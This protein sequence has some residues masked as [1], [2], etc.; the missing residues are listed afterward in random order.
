MANILAYGISMAQQVTDIPKIISYQGQLTSSSG[1]I[2][3]DGEY[4][5]TITLYSD[6]NGTKPIWFD[7]YRTSVR[8]GIF[9]IMLGNSKA[10]PTAI[11][12]QPLWVGAVV[13]GS[14]EMRPL[15]MLSAAAYA[16]NIP[17]ESVTKEKMGTNYIGD[18]KLDGKPII[19]KGGTLNLRSGPGMLLHFDRL[20]NS[21]TLSS[22]G[23]I[24]NSKPQT[25]VNSVYWSEN[26]NVGT[27]AGPN[28]IG[29][30]DTVSLEIH[31]YHSNPDSALDAGRVMRFEMDEG[32][33]PN[34]IGGAYTNYIEDR[35]GSVIMGGGVPGNPNY[36]ESICDNS[37]IAG[38]K[39]NHILTNSVNSAII[40]GVN[41]RI[42][43][44]AQRAVINGGT[45]NIIADTC[46]Y[47]FIGGGA[48]NL[49]TTNGKFSSIL[50]G[51]HLQAQSYAQTVI[52]RY[53]IA[54]GNSNTDNIDPDDRLFIVGN[55]IDNSTRSNAFEVSNNGHSIVYHTNGAA[56]SAIGGSTYK[57]NIIYAWGWVDGS[58]L[59]VKN[60][61]GVERVTNPGPGTYA[62]ELDLKNTDGSNMY[63]DSMSVVATVYDSNHVKL[64]DCIGV[65]YPT[66][67]NPT[68]FVIFATRPKLTVTS[69]PLGL[70]TD[71]TLVW[72]PHNTDFTFI[73]TGRPHEE[74]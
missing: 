1:T 33:G 53:N 19:E 11:M 71:V 52:G 15:T 65:Q 9:A 26:G 39:G 43:P 73:V 10:L 60:S 8:N 7:D 30:S 49:I 28:Y 29:T 40:G 62:V 13:A 50:A 16:I 72:E 54:Q 22:V 20:D 36:I 37:V 41:Q 48:N 67:G 51:D 25:A 56:P 69:T 74:E 2:V 59:T 70:V 21:L 64:G 57:D 31:V 12:N 55:G 24:G 38:G 4:E 32:G 5:I 58:G 14:P 17:N 46:N 35:A 63:L 6:Q 66:P 18:I 3:T 27:V 47:S 45:S 34:I 68:Q 42:G 61:F 44:S 23:D